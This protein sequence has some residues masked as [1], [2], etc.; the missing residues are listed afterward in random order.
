LRQWLSRTDEASVNAP[1]DWGLTPL[2]WAVLSG[3]RE[4]ARILVAGGADP[5]GEECDLEFRAAPLRLALA[6]PDREVVRSLLSEDVV[7]RLQPSP[8]QFL[9]VAVEG[10]HPEALERLL[11]GSQHPVP[12]EHL[13]ALARRSGSPGAE[14]VL[15]QQAAAAGRGRHEKKP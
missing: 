15:L 4:A 1:D 8:G 5:L 7:A 3:R 2:A 12:W 9:D 10:D 6:L 13:L 14:A 11:P